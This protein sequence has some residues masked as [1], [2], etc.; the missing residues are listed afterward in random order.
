[1][2][3][4]EMSYDPTV[5]ERHAA[6]LHQKA[7]SRVAR[8]TVFGLL[9]GS[10]IGG[11]TVVAPMVSSVH[12]LLPHRFAYAALVMGA[13]AGAYLGY[14]VGQSRAVALRL[15]AN[16]AVHQLE[17]GRALHRF[18]ALRVP[19]PAAASLPTPAPVPAPAPAPVAPPAP[20]APAPVV[21]LPEPAPA[22]A[23]MPPPTRIPM[24]VP[25]SD[26]APMSYP[27]PHAVPEPAAQMV[28]PTYGSQTVPPTYE[29]QTPPT[30]NTAG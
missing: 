11:S 23:P 22:P 25:V 20:P 16:L 18:E 7:G 10:V 5:I 2:E 1:M 29:R 28:P 30:S 6:A 14:L 26:P 15:Q 3:G 9:V 27:V 13:A 24:T 8:F 12:S 4:W 21:S 19:L 17:I